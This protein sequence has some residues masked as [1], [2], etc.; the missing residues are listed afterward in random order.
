M[1]AGLRQDGLQAWLR[2]RI[3][4]QRPKSAESSVGEPQYCRRVAEAGTPEDPGALPA[5]G[6]QRGRRLPAEDL[7][8][9]LPSAGRPAAQ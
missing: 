4:R 3:F 1:A 9:H 2:R 8:L 5:G 7:S 6:A